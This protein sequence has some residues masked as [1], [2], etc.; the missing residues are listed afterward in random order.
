[1]YGRDYF[2]EYVGLQTVRFTH[3]ESVLLCYLQKLNV[4]MRIDK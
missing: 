1:M 2:H 4:I 3:T